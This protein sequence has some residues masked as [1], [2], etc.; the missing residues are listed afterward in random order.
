M[1]FMIGRL[2]FLL[3]PAVFFGGSAE[4]IREALVRGMDYMIRSASDPEN[5]EEYASDYLFFFADVSRFE[6]PW[7]QE[8]ARAHGLRLG[9]VY[10]EEMFDLEFADDVVDAA[11]VLWALDF[12]GKDVD[13]PMAVLRLA[14]GR[15]PLEDYLG[16]E[17]WIGRP[18]L[19][20]LIDLLI[21][22]HFTDRVGVPVGVSFAEALLFVEDTG[23]GLAADVRARLFE[24]YFSTKSSGTGLGLAI[25]RQAVEAHGGRIEVDSRRGHGTVFRFRIPRAPAEPTLYSAGEDGQ[26]GSD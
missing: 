16:F 2:V 5:F 7:I 10:L 24:P 25:V 22:F 8:Q 21:G 3:L 9:E 20:L 23:P 4:R 17:P 13:A 6:D 18:D 19:D 12:M 26:E 14:A 1:I 15:F 11:S